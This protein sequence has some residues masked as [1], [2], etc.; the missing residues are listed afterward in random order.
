[1][2]CVTA[3]IYACYLAQKM[4]VP[5]RIVCYDFMDV[6]IVCSVQGFRYFQYVAEDLSI[7]GCYTMSTGEQLLIF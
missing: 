7:L 3:F 6:N 1:M 5:F 2:A 4:V